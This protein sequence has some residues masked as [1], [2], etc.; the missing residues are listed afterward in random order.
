MNN[1]IP[2]VGKYFIKKSIATNEAKNVVIIPRS[3]GGKLNV[4]NLSEEYINSTI[5][6][7]EMAGIPKRKEY[8]VASFFFQ[9]NKSASE[10]VTPDLETPGI[11]A[12]AWPKPIK[13]LSIN[14][15]LPILVSLLLELS[16]KYIIKA[17]NIE[18]R[19]IERFERRTLLKRFGIN[20]FIIKP[21]KTIGKVPIKIDLNNFF[22]KKE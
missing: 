21:R 18:I 2:F 11:I 5:A 6:A 8:F 12:N 1:F 22:W 3:K 13:K 16:A 7:R 17:I 10:M 15:W 9:P 4:E 20:N 14:L 19:P